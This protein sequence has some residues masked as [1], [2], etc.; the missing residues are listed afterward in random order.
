MQ[1]RRKSFR[2]L[3]IILFSAGVLAGMV[4]FIFMNWAYFEASFYFGYS[5]PADKT[6]ITLRC[7]LLM[8]TADSGLVTMSVT[9]STNRD[10]SILIQ[11]EFSYY[12]AATLDKISYPVAAGETRNL[13]WTVTSD[14]LV[15]GHLVM[16]RVYEF[17]AFTLPSRTNTCGTVVV[18]LPAVTGIQVFIIVLVFSLICMAAGWG[19]WIAGNR[20]LQGEGIIATRAMTFFTIIVILGILGGIIGWWGL[21]LICAAAGV[22]LIISVVGYYVQISNPS[23]AG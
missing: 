2:T 20:P 4:M 17:G 3:G 1:S 21:G 6:L 9:N 15:F 10:L 22:L 16:A 8:T 7:P 12:G 23:R 14:N 5:A 13:S 19:L 11:T 18:A